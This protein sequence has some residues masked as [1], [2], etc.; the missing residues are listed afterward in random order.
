MPVLLNAQGRPQPPSDIVARLKEISPLLEVKYVGLPV[1]GE[2]KYWWTVLGKWRPDDP[3]WQSVHQGLLTEEDAYDLVCQ[4]PPDCP[5]D[6]A[7]G[8]LINDVRHRGD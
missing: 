3:R 4:L 5:V 1:A 8:Y 7:V 6:E 2:L